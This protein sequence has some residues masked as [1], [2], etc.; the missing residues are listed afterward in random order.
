MF[1]VT[2]IM[3]SFENLFL[4]HRILRNSFAEK[5]YV[6]YVCILFLLQK[7]LWQLIRGRLLLLILCK[8][9]P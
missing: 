1:S 4:K 9:L 2:Y 3:N 7:P 5:I 8:L 6:V